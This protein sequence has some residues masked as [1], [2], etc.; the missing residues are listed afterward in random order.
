MSLAADPCRGHLPVQRTRSAPHDLRASSPPSHEPLSVRGAILNSVVVTHNQLFRLP[1]HLH[2]I[3]TSGLTRAKL[4]DGTS[5]A[6]ESQPRRE[7][8]GDGLDSRPCASLEDG[9]VCGCVT[10]GMDETADG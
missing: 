10:G 3:T 4:A 2:D 6:R 5:C 1:N 8:L 9:H 7:N